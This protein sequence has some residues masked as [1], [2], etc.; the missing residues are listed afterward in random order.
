MYVCRKNAYIRID[1]LLSKVEK[2]ESKFKMH[3]E[4]KGPKTDRFAQLITRGIGKQGV[5]V[6]VSRAS[7][8][9]KAP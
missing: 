3:R 8:K 1:I 2:L 7:G 6:S 5:R 4:L 9:R